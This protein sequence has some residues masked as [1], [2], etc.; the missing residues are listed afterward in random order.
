[1]KVMDFVQSVKEFDQ[2]IEPVS[3]RTN[4]WPIA[5]ML[6]TPSTT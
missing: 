1:M 4:T 2:V 3:V 6:F 5:F